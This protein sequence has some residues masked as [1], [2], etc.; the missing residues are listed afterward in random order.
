MRQDY[1]VTA[2]EKVFQNSELSNKDIIFNKSI[3]IAYADNVD[4]ITR[5]VRKYKETITAF[6]VEAN[7]M[8]QHQ[9]NHNK[10]YDK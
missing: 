1:V 5:S 10:V 6:K 9:L 8:G 3:L 4:I 7:N 2:L